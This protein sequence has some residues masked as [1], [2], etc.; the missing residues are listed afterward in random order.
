[1]QTTLRNCGVFKV[2]CYT[3]H[4]SLTS[5][6]KAGFLT[7]ESSL[8]SPSHTNDA[9]GCWDLLLCYSDRIAQDFHLIPSS[10]R[11]A[12][13]ESALHMFTMELYWHYSST[14]FFFC[15]SYLQN[16]LNYFEFSVTVNKLYST[17]WFWHEYGKIYWIPHDNI[18]KIDSIFWCIPI[19]FLA[20]WNLYAIFSLFWFYIFQFFGI[21]K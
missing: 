9:M 5:P 18:Y 6:Y 12:D 11:F 1:M 17:K 20:F 21:Q 10:V 13:N 14:S 3:L 8:I 19:N 16:I 7:S 15:Q 2:G 4:G